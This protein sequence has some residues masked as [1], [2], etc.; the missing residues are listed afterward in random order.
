MCVVGSLYLKN[1]TEILK[2][3]FEIVNDFYFIL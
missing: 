3:V 2:Y 1:Y